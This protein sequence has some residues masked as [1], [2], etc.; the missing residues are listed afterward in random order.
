MFRVVVVLTVLTHFLFVGYVVTGGFLALRL[1]RTIGLHV[2]AVLWAVVS[3]TG[4]VGCPLTALER[5]AR[6][7]AGMPPLASEGFIAQYITGVWYPA[8]WASAVQGLVAALVATAWAGYVWRA[9][10]RDFTA[11][12]VDRPVSS[13][14]AL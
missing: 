2:A 13:S 6:Y 5:W 10:R 8:Q 14:G 7:R 11:S 4:H 3:V 9:R 12:D 1:P